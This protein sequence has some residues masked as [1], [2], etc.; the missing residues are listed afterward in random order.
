MKET[1]LLHKKGT[2]GIY[3]SGRGKKKDIRNYAQREDADR[4]ID[5]NRQP[6]INAKRYPFSDTVRKEMV[7]GK[8][9]IMT[10]CASRGATPPQKKRSQK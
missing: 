9:L 6:A 8:A 1:A 4:G 10:D 5:A 7:K 3:Y 2:G